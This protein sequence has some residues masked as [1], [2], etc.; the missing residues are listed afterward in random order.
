[1]LVYLIEHRGRIVAGEEL[2]A[3]LWQQ[4]RAAD[5]YPAAVTSCI[6]EVRRA[7]GDTGR[8][9]RI[10]K[11]WYTHGYRFI[12]PLQEGEH[13]PEAPAQNRDDQ[14]L[15]AAKESYPEDNLS[16][17][18]YLTS[19]YKPVTVL[20][21]T[22]RDTEA[23]ARDRG[24]ET[25]HGLLQAFF[26]LIRDTVRRYGGTIQRLLD[27]GAQVL[28]GM[29]VVY[30]DH[31]RRA[32]LAALELRR[33][34]HKHLAD[35]G[36]PDEDSTAL[37]LA[38]HTGQ[39]IVGPKLE[40]DQP[41][42]IT[43]VGDTFRVL[44]QLR[45]QAAPD[46]ILLS[47]AIRQRVA[48]EVY[49]EALVT[50]ADVGQPACNAYMLQGI[51]SQGTRLALY[52]TRTLS[53]FVGRRLEFDTLFGLWAQAEQGRGQVVGIAGEPGIGK[54]RLLHEFQQRHPGS[55]ATYLRG[56]CVSYGRMTPYLPVVDVLRQG[57]GITETD[58]AEGISTKVRQDTVPAEEIPYLLHLL[59]GVPDTQEQL[60]VLSP[61][62]LKARTLTALCRFW[63]N[64]SRRHPL[65]IEIENLHWLDASSE[66]CLTTLIHYL[67]GTSILLLVSY[68]PGY[69]LPWIDKSYATQLALQPLNARDSQDMVEAVL[70]KNS[71][72]ETHIQ[73][74]VRIAEGNPLFLEELAWVVAEQAEQHDLVVVPDT[75]QAVLMA[76]MDRLPPAAKH[77]LQVAAVIGKHVPLA[78]LQALV[79]LPEETLQQALEGLQAA[80]FLYREPLAV[81]IRYTFKHA[82]TQEAAY[83]SLLRS[84]RRRYHSRVAQVLAQRFHVIVETQP[85]RLA[86]HYTQAGL[87]AEAI[88]YWRQAGQRA[89]ERSANVE[90]ISHLRKGLELV[91]T[92]PETPD[93]YQHELTLRLT[94]G[95]PLLVTQ[96]YASAE[97]ELTYARAH[98]LSQKFG[99]TPD[100]FPALWGLWL[101]YIV[102][103]ALPTA[104]QLAEWLL[105][106]AQ[107]AQDRTL[108]LQSHM[109]LGMVLVHQGQLSP[110]QAHLE[111]SIRLYDA[112]QDP[113]L[114][115]RYTQDSGVVCRVYSAHMLQLQGYPK[116][117]QHRSY[118]ALQLAQTLGHPYSLA[119]AHCMIAL[120]H[121]FRREPLKTQQHA[122]AGFVLSNEYGF[123]HFAAQGN[124]FRG[125]ALGQLGRF[126]EGVDLIR[127]GIAAWVATGAEMA[128]ASYHTLLVEI[129]ERVGRIE[130]DNKSSPRRLRF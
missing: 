119:F 4:K 52:G 57:L 28:F 1:M 24:F 16:A 47:T 59:G 14:A 76:R 37:Q 72:A 46:T 44:E 64:T 42:A 45:S 50:Q 12:A 111:Q 107:Q 112:L 75:V 55:Q 113:T 27:D 63:I 123:P 71:A 6:K 40:H 116:Q 18:S 78:W 34:W 13:A 25:L 99:R 109:A 11:T 23:L 121:Y 122:E 82:L 124:L 3:Q 90:A 38:L 8:E 105:R 126:E 31:A 95:T 91:E 84:T 51:R 73:T 43:A 129:L 7:V 33:R 56:R 96:G 36:V 85:E 48:A 108:Q 130:K 101:F 49:A 127:Q 35:T 83:Q 65:V 9:Q 26:R 125:W 81:E 110:A 114:A 102:R 39:I 79:D 41:P 22:L 115:F 118:E 68:R 54:S 53:V 10:I 29:P 19:E 30:E 100:L 2:L 66:E 93:R 61:Q 97:V 87:S 70:A 128:L 60:A 77:V 58:S 89:I 117:A 106:L 88:P 80:E 62:A 17:P 67:G 32:V 92:L 120:N 15:C 21:C 5:V 20:L 104:Y 74:I 69:Q 103:A 98:E 86:H 94:L